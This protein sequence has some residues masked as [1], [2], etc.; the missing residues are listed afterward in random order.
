MEVKK[1][2]SG[3]LVATQKTK[4]KLGTWGTLE[5]EDEGDREKVAEALNMLWDA[6]DLERGGRSTKHK[7]LA[8]KLVWEHI[9]RMLL[10]N[11]V[12]DREEL[13]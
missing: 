6:L 9:A 11:E 8:H 12:P 5:V 4:P 13:C 10:G 2:P 7:G 3:L 1:N